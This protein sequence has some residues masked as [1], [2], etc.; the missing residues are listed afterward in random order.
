MPEIGAVAWRCP[1]K[2]QDGLA[3]LSV[4]VAPIVAPAPVPLSRAQIIAVTARCL[5]EVGYDGT[6]IR[7]LAT[8]LNCAVGSIY[9]YFTDKRDL[10]STV[11]Q[12]LLEP[13]AAAVEAG[14]PYTITA[15]QYRQAATAERATY[16]L[17]FW[18][19]AL[20]AAP[21]HA[22]PPVVQRI[23]AGWA[24]DLG[25]SDPARQAWA[26]IHADICCG[27]A[28]IQQSAAAVVL[29][30][31]PLPTLETPGRLIVQPV[32]VDLPREPSPPP[33][34]ADPAEPI[35]TTSGGAYLL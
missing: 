25:G 28:P 1:L 34:T 14:Q 15:R 2:T 33:T 23:L 27:A 18:L 8:E 22:L 13:V 4:A 29:P 11:T 31:T 30:P 24:G 9:R 10:L 7:R 20:Q 3:S 5:Q 16:Q 12:Q 19:A 35:T 17:M 32:R 6:T 26:L 21:G